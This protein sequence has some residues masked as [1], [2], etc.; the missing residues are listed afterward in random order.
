MQ[1]A[2]RTPRSYS[3]VQNAVRTPRSYSMVKSLLT[4][5]EQFR[6]ERVE[7]VESQP[8]TAAIAGKIIHTATEAVDEL[9]FHNPFT[10]PGD[11]KEA[12]VSAMEHA[13]R[14]ELAAL[15]GSAFA[16][17][18]TWKTYGRPTEIK[19]NG[20]DLYWFLA[21]GIPFALTAY[22]AWRTEG[23]WVVMRMPDGSPAIELPFV[24]DIGGIPVRG[25]I[26]RVF[27]HRTTN[28]PLVVDLKSGMKPKNDSQLAIYKKALESNL[29][30]PFSW[31][32]YYYG[33]KKGGQLTDP[34][35]LSYWTDEMLFDLYNPAEK[36][37][38]QGLFIPNP[39]EACMHCGVKQHCRYQLSAI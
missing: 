22:V 9:L 15:E 5:G 11:L 21:S 19:P 33:M 39:G 10:M 8:S 32:A 38:E 36:A 7:K 23:E 29:G 24:V 26:D 28:E 25:Y 34:I 14:E 1:Q 4:C 35:D 30:R 17:P 16:D 2:Q 12:W 20:E 18:S 13:T 27:V 3:T 6:L 37:I 31:G